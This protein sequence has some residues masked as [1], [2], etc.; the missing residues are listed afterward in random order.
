LETYISRQAKAN[1][2]QFWNYV[3]GKRKTIT[4]VSDLIIRSDGNEKMLPKIDQENISPTFS[5]VY[6]QGTGYRYTKIVKQGCGLQA[7]RY[8]D[9]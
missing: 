5:G 8:T 4:G 7:G 6:S 9:F 1:P 2:K 3:K